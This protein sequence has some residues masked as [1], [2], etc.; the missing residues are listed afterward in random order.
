MIVIQY[1][2]NIYRYK[3]ELI[4]NTSNDSKAGKADAFCQTFSN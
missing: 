3:S 4:L 1:Y 2:S